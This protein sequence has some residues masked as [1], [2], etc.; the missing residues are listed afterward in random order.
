MKV[1]NEHPMGEGE[2]LGMVIFLHLFEE[3]SCSVVYSCNLYKNILYFLIMR[4]FA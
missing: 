4:I 2:V 1:T 3:I